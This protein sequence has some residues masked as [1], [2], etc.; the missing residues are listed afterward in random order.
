M[1][2]RIILMLRVK[3]LSVHAR[4]IQAVSKFMAVP[5]RSA[6][7]TKDVGRRPILSHPLGSSSM[8]CQLPTEASEGR[9]RSLKLQ[10]SRL[11]V[12]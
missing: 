11:W 5:F 4:N 3:P 2:Q 8:M 6:Q 1:T 7:Q 10:A 9:S 12:A